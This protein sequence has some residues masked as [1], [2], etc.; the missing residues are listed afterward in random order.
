[1]ICS[2]Q[3][4]NTDSLEDPNAAYTN[5]DKKLNEVYQ[6]ILKKHK[7][8]KS[9]INN[10]RNA[11]RL[12]IK[13]RDAQFE[14]NFPESKG[15]YD[16]NTLTAAQAVYLTQLTEE[17]TKILLAILEPTSMGL[18]AYYPFNGNASDESGNGF[19]GTVHGATLTTD[20]FGNSN[21]AYLFNGS[22]SISIPELFQES[23]AAFTIAAWVMKDRIDINTHQI[24]IKGLDQGQ[25]SLCITNLNTYAVLGFGVNL[26]TGVH[27]D[28]NWYYV[29]ITPDTL[30]AKTYYF[31]VGRYIRGEKVDL[32]V[33][34][35]LIGLSAVPDLPLAKWSGHSYSAIGL[36]PEF[37][38]SGWNG[39]IDDIRIYNRALTEAEIDTLY[40]EGGWCRNKIVFQKT[41]GGKR[42]DNINTFIVAPDGGYVAAAY[43]KSCTSGDINVCLFK[44]DKYGVLKWARDFG[45]EG[46]DYGSVGVADE[47]GYMIVGATEVGKGNKDVFVTRTDLKGNILWNKTYG[48]ADDEN[49]GTMRRTQSGDYI[50]TGYTK[51]YGAG[52]AYDAFLMKIDVNGN[53]LWFKRY[54]QSQTDLANDVLEESDG[55]FIMT[56]ATYTPG[57]HD[58]MLIKVNSSGDLLWSKKYHLP[59]QEMGNRI[60]KAANGDYLVVAES[61]PTTTDRV[62]VLYRIDAAGNLRWAKTYRSPAYGRTFNSAR[63]VVAVSD[64]GIVIE[65]K[66]GGS[67][68]DDNSSGFILKTDEDGNVLWCR[69]Y[70]GSNTEFWWSVYQ[71]ADEGFIL[72]GQTDNYG[73]GGKDCYLVKTDKNGKTNSGGTLVDP[74][75]ETPAV[76]VTNVILNCSA[77]SVIGEGR[78]FTRESAS[79][80][81]NSDH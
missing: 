13:F 9:F 17:R 74:I 41:Y 32:L 18:I 78:Q 40:Q 33:N 58:M 56:G 29:N 68:T 23:C 42:D 79:C 50:T 48:G 69:E 14:M 35:E 20:R 39:V 21:S 44:T 11:Q 6:Q 71:T 16:K 77:C 73:A 3:E 47:N 36:L 49:H 24:L 51:S 54:G 28:Q 7:S 64:G 12:W 59:Y 4:R 1:L 81:K 80:F 75:V 65:G 62:A 60:V 26:E 55:S 70:S 76:P 15:H 8:N 34:G 19:N 2:A 63:G 25:A 27:G 30:K 22:A 67:G 31:V 43:S 46:N 10:L 5:A 45:N 66:W 61:G 37:P 57:D 38:N 72:G 53:V 52:P